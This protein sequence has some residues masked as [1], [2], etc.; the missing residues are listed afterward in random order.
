MVEG[1]AK[2]SSMKDCTHC[3]TRMVLERVTVV[4]ILYNVLS[5]MPDPGH[6]YLSLTGSHRSEGI[7]IIFK[8]FERNA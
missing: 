5:F 8:Y 1:R 4:F 7:K 6:D 3:D 2:N